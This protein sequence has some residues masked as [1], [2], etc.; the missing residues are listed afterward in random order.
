MKSIGGL[1]LL[2]GLG[3]FVLHYM[4]MEFKLLMW[5]DNWG[6]TVGTAIRVG[7]IVVGGLLWFVGNKREKAAPAT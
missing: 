7:L 3:S 6:P 2:L 1:M 5:V 4:N